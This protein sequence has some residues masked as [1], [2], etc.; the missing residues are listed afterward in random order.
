MTIETELPAVKIKPLE[1]DAP[2]SWNI[3]KSIVGN[4]VVRPC[5]AR[6]YSHKWLMRPSGQETCGPLY[7][8]EAE[9]QAAAQAD[10]E[11]RVLSALVPSD[12]LKEAEGV[13]R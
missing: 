9:A 6:D 10:Y 13:G 1:W 7:D 11:R 2:D 5:L 4:Y 12:D 3:A 8:S